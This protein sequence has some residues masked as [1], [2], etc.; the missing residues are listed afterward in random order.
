MERICLF[1]SRNAQNHNELVK[2]KK[3]SE[4]IEKINNTLISNTENLLMPMIQFAFLFPIILNLPSKSKDFFS[5]ANQTSALIAFSIVS[6]L[7]AL[8]VSQTKIYFAQP[9]KAN[10]KT[11]FRWIFI[12][13]VTMLQV[14][15]KV[16]ACQV[17][18]FGMGYYWGPNCVM[19]WLFFL[20]YL[21]V[22]WKLVVLWIVWSFRK[23]QA[24]GHFPMLSSSFIFTQINLK[25][26]AVIDENVQGTD[27][28]LI[29]IE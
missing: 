21:L 1:C 23:D 12:L 18:A 22:L 25:E 14:L 16:L 10:Q 9:G 28:V 19:L 24:G 20:P 29:T 15:P 6:S 13:I 27:H 2:L 8:G 3:N 7:M 4:D 11:K 17:F 26:R 5:Y